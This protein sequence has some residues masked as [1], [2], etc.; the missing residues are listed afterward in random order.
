MF[1]KQIDSIFEN[2][3]SLQ[4]LL[5]EANQGFTIEDR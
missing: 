5:K 1:D 4:T 3:K 2:I